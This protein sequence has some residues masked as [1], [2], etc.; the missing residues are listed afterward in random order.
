MN[1]HIHPGARRKGGGLATFFAIGLLG[2]ASCDQGG[3]L[4]HPPEDSTV[5]TVT[6]S[7]PAQTV[8]SGSTIQL[9]ATAWNASG[10]ELAGKE[11][12]WKSSDDAVATVSS[13]GILTTHRDG[14]VT[15]TATTEN[16][17]GHTV[18]Q[19]TAAPVPPGIALSPASVAFS[20]T[21]GQGNPAAQTVNV[22]N[23]GGRALGGLSTTI[24]YAPGQPTGW[25]TATLSSTTAP[26]TVALQPST[27]NLLPGTYTATVVV[28]SSAA[29]VAERSVAVTL[30][31]NPV[32]PVAPAAP[33]NL[34]ASASGTQVTLSW[35]DNSNNETD[36]RIERKTGAAGS[37]SQ[38]G[39]VGANTSTYT[40]AGLSNGTTY[41]YRVRACNAGGCSTYSN[42]ASATTAPAA[43][44]PSATTGGAS[45]VNTSS[46]TVSGSVNPNG[47]ATMAWFEWGTSSTLSNSMSTA[48]QSVGSGTS[49]QTVSANLSGLAA[50]TTYYFRVVAQNS[51]GTSRGG[52]QS[53]TTAQVPPAP[54]S[55]LSAKESDKQIRL[56]W[57]DNS[58]NETEFRIER[59]QGQGGSWSQIATVGANVTSYNDTPQKGPTFYYRVRACN[60]AGCSAYSN[61]ANEKL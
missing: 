9:S 56:T 32:V 39:T 36:F 58:N 29:G 54:P 46:A 12:S 50:G 15:I 6:V 57:R 49:A 13:T 53:F 28:R 26:A 34:A 41:F 18:V 4:L 25:L 33:S 22:T 19:I 16:R 27:A 61:E 5:A 51:A 8:Q 14:P 44:A 45:S 10:T 20:G 24:T 43:I 48:A 35:T 23:G 7:T 17:S 21:I 40:D 38:I 52:V 30:T 2:L 55:D 11:F 42:E 60:S 59:K 3:G 31:V 37:Y 1:V 47:Q